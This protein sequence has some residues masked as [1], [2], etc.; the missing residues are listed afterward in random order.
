MKFAFAA[1]AACI[2]S[3]FANAAHAGLDLPCVP[4]LTSIDT[5][6]RNA[7]YEVTFPDLKQIPAETSVNWKETKAFV[8]A[9]HKARGVNVVVEVALPRHPNPT[10]AR[11]VVMHDPKPALRSLTFGPKGHMLKTPEELSDDT[12]KAYQAA[13]K[14]L[15]ANLSNTPEDRLSK[16]AVTVEP[17]GTLK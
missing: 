5:G 12:A 4:E 15:I 3:L 2:I 13:L 14:T 17:A 6:G 9:L 7:T 11:L 16:D 10:V 8:I 1:V